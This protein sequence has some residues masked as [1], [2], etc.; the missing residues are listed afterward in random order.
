MNQFEP[1][2]QSRDGMAQRVA[3]V[4]GAAAGI[5][6]AIAQSLGATSHTVVLL[7]RAPEV[8]ERAAQL[9]DEGRRAF[10]YQFDAAD[11][12]GIAAACAEIRA[13][14]GEVDVLVNNAGIHSKRDG[15]KYEIEELGLD[16][17]EYTMR[18]NLTSP[19][20]FCQALLPGMKQRGWGRVIN[21]ASRA[22]RTYSAPTGVHYAVSKTG[23]IG[24]ARSIAG[25]YAAYGVTANCIAPGRV[26]TLLSR[27]SSEE[28]RRK[29]LKEIPLGREATTGEIGAAAAFLA[30]DAAA[31]ITGAVLDVNG[32]GFIG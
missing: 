16:V 15:K 31:Y 2:T 12:P 1:P 13:L 25:D 24:L 30:S 7:D 3:L 19:F 9:R 23:L 5:G 6:W 20:V 18:L 22:A 10:H 8:A 14:A 26:D 21:I 4:T 11:L 29:A 27:T 32:G 28:V 17:W